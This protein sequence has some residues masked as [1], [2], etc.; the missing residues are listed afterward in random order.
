M[1]DRVYMLQNTTGV[2]MWS[3][4]VNVTIIE[5]EREKCESSVF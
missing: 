2:V 3:R 1:K 5:R 4:N